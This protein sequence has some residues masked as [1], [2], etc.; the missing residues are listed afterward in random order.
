[1]MKRIFAL[2]LC[3]LMLVP[4]LASCKKDTEEDVELGA[5]IKMYISQMI[6]DFDP[7]YAFN[8]EAALKVISLMF[9]PLF[10]LDEKGKVQNALV[11]DY[12]IKED[13]KS[14][15]YTMTLT[16][17]E[18]SWSDGTSVSADDVVY[19][20]KR[21]LDAS[22]SSSAA[23]LLY[24]IKNARAVKAGDASI[25]DLGIYAVD[26]L[27][28]EIRFEEKIDYDQ[29]IL[30]LTSPALSPLREDIVE[31][32]PDWAK[33]PATIVCSGPF[34]MRKIAYG[35]DS[36][37]ALAETDT[38]SAQLIL[39]R[40]TYYMRDKEKDDIDK[41]VTPYRI[42][43][44]FTK[45]SVEQAA[46]YE[47]GT[48]FYMGD[49]ALESRSYFSDIAEITDEMSTHTYLLNNNIAPFDNVEVRKALS[50]AIDREAIASAIVYA[51][52][53]TALV[54]YGL[55]DSTSVKSLFREVGGDIIS[56]SA[57]IASANSILSAAGIVPSDYTFSITVHEGDEVHEKIAQMV[58][59]TW[60]QLGFNCSVSYL[61]NIINDDIGPTGEK[62]VD[63]RDDLFDEAYA[64][65]NF[66]V[67]AVDIVA[68]SPDA[69]SYLAP[70]AKEFSGQAL[71]INTENIEKP[72]YTLCG[73]ITGFD[74]EEYNALIE[75][76]Y[77]EK[78]IAK[79]AVILHSAEELLL[80]QMPVIPIIFNQ[81][82]YICS[83]DLSKLTSSYYDFRNFD[84]I[85][86]K[87]Y[88]LYTEAN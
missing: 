47:N 5:Y 44:D 21:I 58:S 51:K 36:L 70:F 4:T 64:S 82:A 25:D 17:K 39:E 88:E 20:W 31:R 72:V 3:L 86:L 40:N 74:N 28:L 83:D 77:A 26:T 29:F 75:S 12:E 46:D 38:S 81:D 18:T 13:E 41:Y 45:T 63:I 23:S 33:K 79:R 57:N 16:L 32:N 78:D 48:I 10:S 11:D 7:A 49:F 37:G 8:N 14:N 61:G 76:A 34:M 24:D 43:I 84:K 19:A 87:D 52:A 62:A 9:E 6:Y 54:P 30:N 73:H 66:D 60:C 80:E 22:N 67:I 53:A 71:N 56:K 85:K 27:V 69:F 15:E 55:Y 42:T 59:E 68:Y 35:A 2:I 1:M 65:G 50:V